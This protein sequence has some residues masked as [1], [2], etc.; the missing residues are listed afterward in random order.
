VRLDRRVLVAAALLLPAAAMAQFPPVGVPRGLVRLDLDGAFESVD[1]AYFDGA[2]GEFAGELGSPALGADRIPGL[3]D[4]DTRLTRITGDPGARLDLGNLAATAQ[5]SRPVGVIGL[6]VGVTSHLTLFARLPLARAS[7]TTTLTL[8]STTSNAGV[9]PADPIFGTA[10]G[11]TQTAA[12]FQDFGTALQSLQIRLQSGVYDGDPTL[13]ALAQTTL[14]SGTA[15]RN[16]L[17]GLLADPATVSAFAPTATSTLGAAV[18][19]RLQA[20]Q[21]ALAGS[22]G[23]AGFASA[24]ALPGARASQGDFTNFLTNANGPIV[25]RLDDTPLSQRGDAEVGGVWTLVDRWNEDAHGFGLRAAVTGVARLGTGFPPRADRFLDLGTGTG[26]SA[27]GGAITT[28]V[29]FGRLAARITAGYLRQLA[30]DQIVRLTSPAQPYAPFNQIVTVRV[31]PG[32]VLTL[33]A[34]PMLRLLP[35]FGVQ[36][37][38]DY[39]RQAAEQVAYASATDSIPGIPA[40]ILATDSRIGVTT[41]SAGVTYSRPG[42][43]KLGST[44]LPID[45]S[46]TFEQVIAGS[47]GRVLKTQTMRA[48]LRLYHRLF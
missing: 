20:L 2:L 27:F 3:T 10:A 48:G 18:T 21:T 39:W 26:H 44:G 47:G 33:G 42:A 14:A 40:S 4:A 7:V 17:F 43:T 30:G 28:D 37:G 41:F 5:G 25:G 12:F 23:I 45:A 13:R 9:N 6:A 32:D 19:A 16:D 34:H 38:V 8:D 46:W 15:L 1:R 29:G 11:A 35:S 31:N 24:P 22:L 36:A